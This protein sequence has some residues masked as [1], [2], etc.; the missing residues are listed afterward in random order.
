MKSIV[1]ISTVT[2]II[3]LS[4][5][6]YAFKQGIHQFN[7]T[8]PMLIE[9]GFDEDSAD[10][11][12]D[13]NW[14]TD[15]AE[16]NNESA[17]ADNNNLAGASSRLRNKIQNIGDDLQDCKRRSA[18]D[19][20]GEALHTVQDV[21]SHSN[22]VDNSISIPDILNMV[23]GVAACDAGSNFAPDG[24]VTG[25]FSTFGFFTL[26]QCRGMPSGM[27]CHRD[28]NKDNASANNGSK[29]ELAQTAAKV[30]SKD[31]I[32]LLFADIDRRFSV[33]N[34]SFYKK[35]LKNKQ[36]KTIFVIDTTGSME[37]DIAQV[38][39]TVNIKLDAIVA[40]DDAP[41]L[42]LVTF[43]DSV[44]DHG[45]SCDIA[46]FRQQINSLSVGGGGDCPEASGRAL[47][48][49][50]NN[51]IAIRNDI[52]LR[53]GNILLATDASASNPS[54][55]G[56]IKARAN[57]RGVSIS[58]IVTGDCVESSKLSFKSKIL[59][60]SNN[61]SNNKF[62]KIAISKKIENDPLESDSAR[63]MFQALASQTGGVSFQVNRNEVNT[64]VP[65][66][67]QMTDPETEVTFS[68]DVAVDPIASSDTIVKIDNT[69]LSSATIFMVMSSDGSTLPIMELFRP[70]GS[71]VLETD[72]NIKLTT[73]SSLIA[74][75]VTAPEAGDWKIRLSDGN[76][77]YLLRTFSKTDFRVNGVRFLQRP[78]V[79]I[80]HVDLVPIQGSP[81][82]GEEVFVQIRFTSS[83]ETVGLEVRREDETIIEQPALS[84]VDDSTRTYQASFIVP[85]ENFHLKLV[86]NVAGGSAYQREFPVLITPQT[87]DLV[88]NEN[89]KNVTPGETV[90]FDLSINNSSIITR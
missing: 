28:L 4:L 62:Q 76:S 49:A 75:E 55:L 40:G 89:S 81:S 9:L 10:E 22:S 77:R 16:P 19:R 67:L 7:I 88:L 60:S 44:S 35:M 71:I 32:N 33:E 29:T 2:L 87:V 34:A 85:N 11:V 64:V 70:D 6:V 73:I 46:E 52:T 12:G 59:I 41:T 39:A 69:M 51:F 14:Y 1:L 66:Y 37:D 83:P 86:G 56:A 36:E 74:Y 90:N 50:L 23:N 72:V 84:L 48:T 3:T 54:L 20:L 17:H 53:G 26:N 5:E 61:E 25:Y 15:I 68:K 21:Y 78:A 43:K 63:I 24:L 27:C 38:Q 30:A 57:G 82:V 47:A 80:R 31:Y 58:S 79:Q 42:G 8:E 13:S 45:L 65:I 18:L